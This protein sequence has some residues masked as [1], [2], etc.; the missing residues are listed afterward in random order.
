MARQG[1]AVG[2]GKLALLHHCW[3]RD[4]WSWGAEMGSWAGFGE[5]QEGWAG[6]FRAGGALGALAVSSSSVISNVIL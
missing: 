2:R 3:G 6:A 4:C 1:G 5:P